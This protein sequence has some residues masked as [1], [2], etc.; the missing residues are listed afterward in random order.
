MKADVRHIKMENFMKKQG[1]TEDGD[2]QDEEINVCKERVNSAV[3]HW[4]WTFTS[5][6]ITLY[7]L[8]F[9]DIRILTMTVE[10]DDYFFSI[11]ILFML[12]FIVEISLFSYS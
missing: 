2:D 3:E 8:F 5:T 12:F 1:G 10:V 6:F 9:D 7:T 4:A 11:T